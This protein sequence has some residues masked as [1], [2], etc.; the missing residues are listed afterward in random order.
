MKR[1]PI[2]LILL[3]CFTTYHCLFSQRLCGVVVDENSNGLP[4][5]LITLIGG[6]GSDS[7]IAYE[8]SDK[9]GEWCFDMEVVGK[10]IKVD[11][12]G[13]HEHVVNLELQ[14]IDTNITVRLRPM[15][16]HL[17]DVTITEKKKYINIHGD[18]LEYNVAH[19]RSTTD[20]DLK[21]LLNKM[22]GIEVTKDGDIKYN[23]R[24]VDKLLVEGK[25][26]LNNQ[27][28]ITV[29]ALSPTIIK[30]IQIIHDYKP[31]HE[32]FFDRMSPKVAMNFLLTD[33]A[34]Q[35]IN[36]DAKI[37]VG[38]QKKYE[39]VV[40]LFKV[41]ESMGYSSFVRSNNLGQQVITANDF[42]NM[43]SDIVRAVNKSGGNFE[44]LM[45][46]GFMRQEKDQMSSDH[47]VAF[48][49][50]SDKSIRAK[51]KISLLT[52]F[53]DRKS[54]SMVEQTYLQTNKVL[55]AEQDNGVRSPFLFLVL[56]RKI[57]LSKKSIFEIDIPVRYKSNFSI[58][59]LKGRIGFSPI[60][61]E[62]L[63]SGNNLTISPNIFFSKKISDR[64]KFKL[65]SHVKIHRKVTHVKID[66]YENLFDSPKRNVFQ[67][68][69]HKRIEYSM[70]GKLYFK[71][72]NWYLNMSSPMNLEVYSLALYDDLTGQN[73]RTD[74]YSFSSDVTPTVSLGYK[75]KSIWVDP[76]VSFSHSRVS[77]DQ[78]VFSNCFINPSLKVRYNFSSLHFFLLKIESST[79]AYDPF[80][81]FSAD[82][83]EDG[84]TLRKNILNEK[85][86]SEK[87]TV[88]SV[89]YFRLNPSSGFQINSSFIYGI[90][91]NNIFTNIEVNENYV[92]QITRIAKGQRFADFRSSLQKKY[93]K[94]RLIG[95][96][97]MSWRHSKT[98]S[99]GEYVFVS[100][101]IGIDLVTNFKK[102]INFG[103]K[104]DVNIN[105]QKLDEAKV[106][107]WSDEI[108]GRMWYAVNRFRCDT[109]ITYHLRRGKEFASG[110]VVW[111]FGFEIDALK[112]LQ[113]FFK[114]R[115]VL[116]L[117]ARMVTN[118]R[119]FNTYSEIENYIRFPGSLVVGVRRKF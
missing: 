24:R 112:S 44:N 4:G 71:Y 89:S 90:F 3:F 108:Y 12:L 113:L 100:K 59:N 78:N 95:K 85:E 70:D 5:A 116:N 48:N 101:N 82:M 6:I 55:L 11:I 110:F 68:T 29:E 117:N 106:N 107:F 39:G 46:K 57:T 16:F 49:F 13:Y 86:Q 33:E 15:V 41:N 72:N 92:T 80:L 43:E 114:G 36:G 25:D 84:G 20:R 64:F 1:I 2:F 56:N 60:E 96:I 65:E 97:T 19:Y 40:N 104:Y 62:L 53:F 115:D 119:L 77:I 79:A 83:I 35:K 50:E 81:R 102:G 66:S 31:F 94:R 111:N 7:I 118:N 93:F 18:T 17:D 98:E 87:S 67:N 28:K 42:L 23:S 52:N 74:F 38:V 47:L 32:K 105:T 22:E 10:Q 54:T 51:N 61:N 34:K 88:F 99:D 21:D 69:S 73:R 103:V 76:K 91:N 75:T 30:K 58:E 9:N 14:K 8:T 37:G 26:I 45:P 27:H 109:D 63:K